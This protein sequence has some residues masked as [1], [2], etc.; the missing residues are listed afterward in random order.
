MS[1]EIK[2]RAWVPTGDGITHEM[3][4]PGGK[5]T[6]GKLIDTFGT[7][8]QYTGLKDRTGKEI[9]EGDVIQFN[10]EGYTEFGWGNVYGQVVWVDCSFEVSMVKPKTETFWD[11]ENN[12]NWE[13]I[14]NIYENPDLIKQA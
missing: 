3:Y 14:G 1:R 8:M 13:I 5:V 9:Y 10:D 11:L 4:Y 7:V 2:F 6:T 12:E